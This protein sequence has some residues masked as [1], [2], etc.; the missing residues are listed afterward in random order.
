MTVLAQRIWIGDLL[1][2]GLVSG[3][4]L[5]LAANLLDDFLRTG[6]VTGLLLLA[7]ELLVAVF[8]MFRRRT[9]EVDRS[10]ITLAL[11]F[12]SVV[13]PPLL[14]TSELGSP[15]PDAVTMSLSAIGLIIVILGKLA[16]GRSFGIVPANRGVVT[17]GPYALVRH[18]IYAGYLITHVAFVAAHPLLRNVLI[19]AIADA[20][21]VG[22]ALKE[23]QTL[24]KD[25]RYQS[26]C[27]R[28]AWHLVPRVF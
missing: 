8:M 18:P 3:L 10:P 13:G 24:Q 22:R 4:F 25:E 11:T 2:R 23:E 1:A 16:L 28:V 21:L 15:V 14:R 27:R 26:Y 17:A 7:S 5:T 12:A 9:L 19:I 20:A 6:R